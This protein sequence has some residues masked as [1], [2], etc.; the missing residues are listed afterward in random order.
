VM[1]IELVESCGVKSE[2]KFAIQMYSVKDDCGQSQGCKT[3]A[4]FFGV[5]ARTVL[6]KRVSL[7]YTFL[8]FF[9]YVGRTNELLCEKTC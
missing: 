5:A 8:L 2:T 7:P 1:N 4:G 6:H 3:F 9:I